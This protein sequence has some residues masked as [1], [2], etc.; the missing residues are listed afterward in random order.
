M[1][2]EGPAPSS[3]EKYRTLLESPAFSAIEECA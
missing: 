2:P 1:Q 3:A